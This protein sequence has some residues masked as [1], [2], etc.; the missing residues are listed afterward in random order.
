MAIYCAND[1]YCISNTGY[2]T[3]DDTYVAVSDYNSKDY[4]LGNTNG[5]FIYFT[6]S[7]WCLSDSLGGS[8]NLQGK[9]PYNWFLYKLN[10]ITNIFL[11]IYLAI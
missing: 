1:Y 5:K 11:K 4:Y 6:G 7:Y 3:L 10:L 9:Y 8:C 2:P